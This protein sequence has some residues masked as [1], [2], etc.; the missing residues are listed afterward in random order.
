MS[1]S[2]YCVCV[3]VENQRDK[4]IARTDEYSDSE[5]EGED[6]SQ[7]GRRKNELSYKRPRLIDESNPASKAAGGSI[8]LSK[9]VTTSR[10]ISSPIPPEPSPITP[11]P[12][13]DNSGASE[14]KGT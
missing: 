8:T 14:T 9:S 7:G 10:S 6:P 11:L 12:Q 1:V 5:D 2:V 3:C 13:E 4:R